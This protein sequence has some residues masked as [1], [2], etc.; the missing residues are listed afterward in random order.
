MPPIRITVQL[1]A[2]Q[3]FKENSI[4]HLYHFASHI[5]GK[6][7]LLEGQQAV[8]NQQFFAEV[9]LDEP[10]HIA[11][12]DK[13][14]IRS[15]DDSLTLAGAEVLEIHSPKRHKCTEARLALVKKFSKNH[16]L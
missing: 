3:A 8:K 6:L 12:G 11:V 1:T 10:L 4:V 2:N 14:I 5:T 9:V 16:R 13:L 15:G 7:N